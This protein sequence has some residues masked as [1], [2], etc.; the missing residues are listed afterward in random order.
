MTATPQAVEEELLRLNSGL[1]DAACKTLTRMYCAGTLD[2]TEE[3]D[4]PIGQERISSIQGSE[5]HR[6]FREA[7]VRTSLEIGFAYGYSTIWML[8]AVS[9]SEN[10]SHVAIDPFEKSSWGG[11][12]LWQVQQT[13]GFEG[14]FAWIEDYSICA[15]TNYFKS[16]TQFDGIFIDGSHRFDDVLVDF[17]LADKVLKVG[18][19]MAF[20][21]MW[22]NSIRSVISFI[23]ENRADYVFLEQGAQ[24][25]AVFV[26]KN[27]DSR[28]WRHFKPFATSFKFSAVAAWASRRFH[29]S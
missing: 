4:R 12:G 7:G 19:V 21:D 1:S 6:I 20:D 29:R 14:R 8:D 16:G 24:N 28:D 17:Y 3:K 9:R 25:M 10:G 27:C 22:M 26:K 5:L 2:G 18:G 15:L 13:A 23:C 11:V